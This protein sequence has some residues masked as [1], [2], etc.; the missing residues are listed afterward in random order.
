[1]KNLKK[2]IRKNSTVAEIIIFMAGII[3]VLLGK[4]NDA[5]IL[6]GVGT[7]VIASA[8]VVFMTDVFVGSD[9]REKVRQWGLEGVYPT[10]GERNSACDIHLK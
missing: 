4:N 7:S 6:M 10:R 5:S 9:D 3:L 2:Y 8:I 1:M